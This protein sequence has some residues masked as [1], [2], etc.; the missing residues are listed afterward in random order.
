MIGNQHWR[1]DLS[2]VHLLITVFHILI[3][4]YLKF[5]RSGLF[6]MNDL[7]LIFIISDFFSCLILPTETSSCFVK[8]QLA[9]IKHD[10][11]FL[12]FFTCSLCLEILMTICLSNWRSVLLL[13]PLKVYNLKKARWM[14]FFS[15]LSHSF[16][17]V[18]KIKNYFT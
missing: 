18:I 2:W 13:E 5:I 7:Y 10:T 1:W 6:L 14:C 4:K 8:K 3:W 9:F 11:I 16:T 15:M 17:K 12:F